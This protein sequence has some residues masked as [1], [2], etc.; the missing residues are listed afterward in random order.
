MYGHGKELKA[1]FEE[2][3]RVLPVTEELAAAAEAVLAAVIADLD[4]TQA[5]VERLGALD[6]GHDVEQAMA[7]RRGAVEALSAERSRW[8]RIVNTLRQVPEPGYDPAAGWAYFEGQ[9][10]DWIPDPDPGT[11]ANEGR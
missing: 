2:F 10:P 4:Q 5:E 3:A 1:A 9:K 8:H 7:F 6:G 11:A